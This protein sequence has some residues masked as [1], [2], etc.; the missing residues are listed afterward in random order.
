[1][2]ETER[3]RESP[4]KLIWLVVLVGKNVGKKARARDKMTD[5]L[6]EMIYYT[7]AVGRE[8]LGSRKL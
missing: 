8:F 4:G 2:K 5:G 1:M 6:E 3:E 7:K